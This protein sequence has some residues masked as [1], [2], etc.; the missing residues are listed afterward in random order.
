M[1]IRTFGSM[2]R[3]WSVCKWRVISAIID[4]T[5]HL[6]T[7]GKLKKG[8]IDQRCEQD[9]EHQQGASICVLYMHY[10]GTSHNGCLSHTQGLKQQSGEVVLETRKKETVI[11]NYL[12]EL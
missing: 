5:L 10:P 6:G 11:H 4:G 12:Q 8:H 9:L 3:Y 2:E 7:S 1:V